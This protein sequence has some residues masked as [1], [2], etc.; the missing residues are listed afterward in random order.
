LGLSAADLSLDIL[1]KERR[2]YRRV[3]IPENV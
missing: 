1:R 3:L 2:T